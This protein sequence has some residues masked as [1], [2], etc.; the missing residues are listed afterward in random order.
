MIYLHTEDF[1]RTASRVISF[2]TKPKTSLQISSS[3]H[4]LVLRYI[5][6][7]FNPICIF[8]KAWACNHKFHVTV[9]KGV[10]VAPT[11]EVLVSSYL[12]CIPM[13]IKEIRV[14]FRMKN[15]RS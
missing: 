3:N 15:A 9:L 14:T 5:K 12:P 6:R 7:E 2:R 13:E 11:S 10:N 4:I 1:S 8:L